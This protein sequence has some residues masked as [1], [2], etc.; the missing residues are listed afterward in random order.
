MRT[1]A[2]NGLRTVSGRGQLPLGAWHGLAVTIAGT[3]I[4]ASAGSAADDL[5]L[6]HD[7]GSDATGRVGFWTKR[8]SVTMFRQIAIT[9]AP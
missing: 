8:D 5:R 9:P 6:E 4:V 7:L 1:A 3:R 2:A